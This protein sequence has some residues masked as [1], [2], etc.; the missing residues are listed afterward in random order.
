[1]TITGDDAPSR[2]V[3]SSYFTRAQIEDELPGASVVAVPPCAQVSASSVDCGDF[4]SNA[5]V[6]ANLGGGDDYYKWATINPPQEIDGGAGS[7]TIEAGAGNDAVRGGAG[8]DDL[9][10]GRGDDT[11]D[12]GDGNDKVDGW[13]GS[14]TVT[15]GAGQ[16]TLLGDGGTIY[17]GGNDTLLARDGEADSLDCGGG[18]DRA[19]VDGVDVVNACAQVDRP[20]GAGTGTPGTGQTPAP[21]A[22]SVDG[23]FAGV[24]KI[25]KLLT[26][27][28]VALKLTPTA[29]C[30]ARVA[31]AVTA[32]EAKRLKLGRK[33]VTLGTS[34]AAQLT[35]GK[36]A[37]VT[38]TLSR[39]YRAKLRGARRI[40]GSMIVACAD[41]SGGTFSGAVA[42]KL[43]R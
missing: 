7:D 11:L 31:L 24:P 16:D 37:T 2:L 35:A 42:V 41:A 27:A 18:A 9:N 5:R 19:V 14:D 29:A 21:Q 1:M 26:G 30:T 17:A 6:V 38:V 22:L 36:A 28:P 25:G 12:G 43:R 10:G 15:G 32:T 40:N 3:T 8:N 23:G 4:A 13:D 34:R 33:A 39:S 20:A